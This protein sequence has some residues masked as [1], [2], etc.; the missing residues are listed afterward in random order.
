M[1]YVLLLGYYNQEL[2]VD[3]CTWDSKI[4]HVILFTIFFS[5]LL[6]I[7]LNENSAS[8]YKSPRIAD[9]IPDNTNLKNTV[10]VKRTQKKNSYGVFNLVKKV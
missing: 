8:K 7:C 4:F 10:S 2:S 9:E 6:N 5:L 1:Y 3:E